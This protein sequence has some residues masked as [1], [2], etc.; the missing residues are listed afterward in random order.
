MIVLGRRGVP[1]SA[2][3]NTLMGFCI[4]RGLGA[5]IQVD[6]RMTRDGIPVCFHDARLERTTN[7]K[8]LVRSFTLD[9]LKQLDAGGWFD[10]QFAMERI[11]T[12]AEV[13]TIVTEITVC[14]RVQS[15]G[16]ESRILDVIQR[17]KSEDNT[18]LLD[19]VEAMDFPER[20][21]QASPHAK[22]IV[23]CTS[24]GDF[25]ALRKE[26]ASSVVGVWCDVSQDDWVSEGLAD[27]IRSEGYQLF[28][29]AADRKCF[30]SLRGLSAEA[31]CSTHPSDVFT[32]FGIPMKET[33]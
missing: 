15:P 33:S 4:A 2:P 22:G 6:V 26:R 18:C 23:T 12:L 20:V 16:S 19:S 28:L 17:T 21:L 32:A 30:D 8:G 3:E 29:D 14:I 13:L 9:E 25:A 10:E 31:I 7:G 27:E 24:A 5:G 11:P 1:H